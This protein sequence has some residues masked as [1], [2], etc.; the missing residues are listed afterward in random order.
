VVECPVAFSVKYSRAEE[1]GIKSGPYKCLIAS[2][3]RSVE[4]LVIMVDGQHGTGMTAASE[5]Q[6]EVTRVIKARHE[7]RLQGVARADASRLAPERARSRVL[8]GYGFALCLVDLIRTSSFACFG[9]L[10]RNTVATRSYERIKQ[11]NKTNGQITC[12]ICVCVC[13]SILSRV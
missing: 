3:D 8:Y 4:L 13:K 9:L 7:E 10:Y 2:T 12:V 6:L 1:L 5:H 11:I